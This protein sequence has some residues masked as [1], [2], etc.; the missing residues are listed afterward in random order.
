MRSRK[1]KKKKSVINKK[2]GRPRKRLIKKVEKEDKVKNT[3]SS[4]TNSDIEKEENISR[5]LRSH[6]KK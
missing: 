3:P 6:K 2:R 5:K 4:A 1:N